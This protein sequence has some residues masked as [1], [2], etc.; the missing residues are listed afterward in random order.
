MQLGFLNDNLKLKDL[1]QEPSFANFFGQPIV[2]SGEP[3]GTM[4]L[5]RFLI[6]GAV[7][8]IVVLIIAFVVSFFF[9]AN[10]IIY[11][12]LRKGADDI[13]LDQVHTR[14]EDLKDRC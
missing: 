12:L 3:L 1:W 7:L 9:T 6:H 14:E 8:A 5:G 2:P 13:P 11:A 4:V 10:T